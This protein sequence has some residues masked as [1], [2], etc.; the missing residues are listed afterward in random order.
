MFAA[1]NNETMRIETIV[2]LISMTTLLACQGTRAGET[3]ILETLKPAA[4]GAGKEFDQIPRE[5]QEALKKTGDFVKARVAAQQP[6]EMTFI[7]THNSRRSHLGQVWAQTAAA[8]YGVP[9]VKAYSGGTQATACNIRTVRALRRAGFSVAQAKPGT[10]PEYLI[11]YA[12]TAEPLRAFS[13]VYDQGGNPTEK[14]IAIMTCSQADAACP[15]VK[16]SAARVAIP[17]EDPKA[18]DGTADED[19]TYDARSRQIAREMFFVMS[20]VKQ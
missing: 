19:A 11:Q 14:Y 20:H 5:R 4:A 3:D 8:Y 6:V 18:S 15:I 13:K 9:G 2:T 16:G 7:C 12:E 17:Y 10:N 1:E